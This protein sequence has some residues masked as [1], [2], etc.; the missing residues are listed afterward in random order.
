MWYWNVW[1]ICILKISSKLCNFHKN[2]F[3]VKPKKLSMYFYKGMESIPCQGFSQQSNK[4]LLIKHLSMDLSL[5]S[6]STF[7]HETGNYNLI[8]PF[9]Q[10][11]S[12][13]LHR[14]YFIIMQLLWNCLSL[15]SLYI[16]EFSKNVQHYFSAIH[17]YSI[18]FNYFVVSYVN[19]SFTNKN[20]FLLIDRKDIA[21]R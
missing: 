16:S 17:I 8:L 12:E 5:I 21:V 20:R 14:L 6:L 2:N 9:T 3:L 1:Q 15:M 11:I 7:C 4:L 19:N 13:L 18:L 10:V